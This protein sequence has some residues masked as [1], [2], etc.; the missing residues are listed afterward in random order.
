M[1]RASRM[2]IIP[3]M[4]GLLLITGCVRPFHPT[5]LDALTEFPGQLEDREEYVEESVEVLQEREVAGGMV[6]L[7][8][9][10]SPQSQNAGTYCMA[11]TFVR[12]CLTLRGRGWQPG[13]S[14]LLHQKNE[15]SG[16]EKCSIPAD[17]FVVGYIVRD[18]NQTSRFTTVSGFSQHGVSV[19]IVWSDGQEDSAPL[20]N[21]SFLIIR[22]GEH[23]LRRIELLDADGSVIATEEW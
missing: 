21:S 18:D 17:A 5:P 2:R 13:T 4:A 16:E 22:S 15:V 11:D 1:R 20:E 6:L 9:W 3:M 10:Q 14:M 19:S 23:E 8:R 12:P 7:Y